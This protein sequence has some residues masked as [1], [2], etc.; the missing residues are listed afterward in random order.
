MDEMLKKMIANM[1]EK[2]GKS[3]EEW[4]TLLKT[5]TF[6]K[7][8]E[9]VNFLKKEHGVTHG[10]ANTIVHL[11]KKDDTETVDLVTAQ[12]EKKPNLKPIYDA[13]KTYIET[14][15][16]DVEFAPKKAYVSVRRKKQFAIIQP[17]TKTRLDLGLNLKGKE[18]TDILENSG[19]FNAMCSHRIRLTTTEEISEAVETW[20]KEAYEAA[21]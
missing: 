10:F 4:F 1:P 21:G 13:L 3:L 5:Q 6:V 8:S 14:L 20:I 12:Y 16:S 17:S 9:A 15:G 11:S 18:A 19:S 2:T 7:H